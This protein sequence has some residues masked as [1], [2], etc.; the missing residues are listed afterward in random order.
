M[1]WPTGRPRPGGKTP[2]SGR[3]KGAKNILPGAKS[4]ELREMVLAALESVGGQEYLEGVARMDAKAFV[5]LI[6]RL[7]PNK[8]EAEVTVPTTIQVIT[9]FARGPYDRGKT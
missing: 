2:G 6:S 9:G 3:K 8:V 4:P 5:S 7:L 1:A